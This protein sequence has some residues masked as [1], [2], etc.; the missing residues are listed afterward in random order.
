MPVLVGMFPRSFRSLERHRHPGAERTPR[1]L[2]G[3][4]LT[5]RIR[6]RSCRTAQASATAELIRH[7]RAAAVAVVVKCQLSSEL[8]W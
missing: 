1:G 8:R 6:E 7:P 2:R 3:K 5:S 4:A